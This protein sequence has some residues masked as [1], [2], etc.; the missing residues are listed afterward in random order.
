MSNPHRSRALELGGV[1]HQDDVAGIGNDCQRHFHF[2]EI[3]IE[4]SPVR[5]D[6]EVPMTA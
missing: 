3:E 1:R 5:V 2:S 6:A 4:Q